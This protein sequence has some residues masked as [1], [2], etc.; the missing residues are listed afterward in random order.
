MTHALIE[1]QIRQSSRRKRI[2]SLSG[3]EKAEHISHQNRIQS[4]FTY[5]VHNRA[6]SPDGA[7]AMDG[8]DACAVCKPLGL[9]PHRCVCSRTLRNQPAEVILFVGHANVFRYWLC[10]AL[11]VPPEAWLRISLPH[12]SLTELLLQQVEGTGEVERTVTALRI[13]DDGHLPPELQTR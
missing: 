4:S 13:G 9:D 2:Q 3:T 12:G 6:L 10:R 11:Q 1:H 7:V 5:H 8:P